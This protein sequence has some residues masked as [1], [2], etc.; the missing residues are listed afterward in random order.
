ML[1]VLLLLELF[2]DDD[3]P[4]NTTT[5]VPPSS[6]GSHASSSPLE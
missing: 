3:C 5:S 4:L 2:D 1:P 6:P